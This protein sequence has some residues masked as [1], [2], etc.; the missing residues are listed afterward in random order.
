[1]VIA[2]ITFYIANTN[3]L[4][5]WI[6]WVGN[7]LC[8]VALSAVTTINLVSYC[9]HFLSSIL[10]TDLIYGLTSGQSATTIRSSLSEGTHTHMQI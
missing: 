8:S 10:V 2:T 7:N 5:A 4:P 9:N 3:C 6:L 1:M